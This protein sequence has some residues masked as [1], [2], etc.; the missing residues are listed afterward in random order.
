MHSVIQARPPIAMGQMV[1]LGVPVGIVEGAQTVTM[2]TDPAVAKRRTSSEL[3][4]ER[5]Q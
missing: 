3:A 2:Q 4:T 1:L 5:I